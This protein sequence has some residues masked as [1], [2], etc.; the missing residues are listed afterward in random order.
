MSWK[1]IGWQNIEDRVVLDADTD[2]PLP[3]SLRGW[4]SDVLEAVRILEGLTMAVP[5]GQK[6]LS[7]RL[8]AHGA[9]VVEI[10]EDTQEVDFV[11]W[12]KPT[13]PTR[14]DLWGETVPYG[15][16]QDLLLQTLRRPTP[17][18]WQAALELFLFSPWYTYRH[19]FEFYAGGE[20]DDWH[21]QHLS[22]F[23][24]HLKIPLR[25]GDIR[26]SFGDFVDDFVLLVTHTNLRTHDRVSSWRLNAKQWDVDGEH[27]MHFYNEEP[28]L[29]IKTFGDEHVVETFPLTPKEG[30]EEKAIQSAINSMM[31]ADY[32]M[33][34]FPM[35]CPFL[36][37]IHGDS[38]GLSNYPKVWWE[39]W[40]PR[41]AGLPLEDKLER[42]RHC[43]RSMVE[44]KPKAEPASEGDVE[45]LARIDD[46]FECEDY[47]EYSED[48]AYWDSRLDYYCEDRAPCPVAEAI[49]R[50][51][52]IAML[53]SED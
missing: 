24:Q 5:P 46:P 28:F 40:N 31:T 48:G 25:P 10:S 4:R 15:G 22:V 9:T 39:D 51:S 34:K 27:W 6:C 3:H 42:W 29:Y 21:C 2:A 20:F 13:L 41:R 47:S 53:K 44:Q 17:F 43:R 26:S 36:F 52:W 35:F 38:Y 8:Q 14:E 32:S 16:D 50:F 11:V 33:L 30:T 18:L 7:V 1:A 45:R 49:M 19:Y 37:S 23:C 12:S